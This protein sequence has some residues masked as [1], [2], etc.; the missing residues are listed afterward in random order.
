MYWLI[1]RLFNDA[2]QTVE[3]ND[4]D[5]FF[6]SSFRDTIPPLLREATSRRTLT[7][8]T[9]KLVSAFFGISGFQ[10]WFLRLE[11]YFASYSFR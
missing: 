5:V 9:F 4:F 6:C 3:V 1:L 10:I 11:N 7:R 2:V 8:L